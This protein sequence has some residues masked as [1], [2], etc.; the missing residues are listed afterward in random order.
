MDKRQIIVAL[1]W[2][3]LLFGGCG[4]QTPNST[5]RLIEGVPQKSH[6]VSPSAYEA[7]IQGQ[8]AL[9]KGDTPAALRFLNT[10]LM[11][12]SNSPY[13][14]T[15]VAEIYGSMKNS[16][17]AYEHLQQALKLQPDFPDALLL[18][19]RLYWQEKKLSASEKSF[20]RYIQQN[21]SSSAGYLLYAELLERTW[22]PQLARQ[23]LED[24]ARRVPDAAEAHY[25][26][27]V[28]CLRQVDYVCAQR[29]LQILLQNRSDPETL[30]HLAHV[31]RALG[32]LEEGIRLLREAFD[33]SDGDPAVASTLIEL[34]QQTDKI[35]AIDDLLE[36]FSNNI[37]DT[38]EQLAALAELCLEAR[39][40]DRALRL[41][42]NQLKLSDSAVW[43]LIQAEALTQLKKLPEAKDV[44]RALLDSPQGVSAT[45]RL[46]RL[47][48]KESQYEE[49]GK[50]LSH[51][52]QQYG[53]QDQLLITLSEV[54]FAQG[55]AEHSIQVIRQALRIYPNNRKLRFGLGAALERVG[56]WQE[57]IKEMSQILMQD[58]EDAMAHN[59]I[60]YT[61]V[62]HGVDLASAQ[63]SI[64]RALFLQ[65]GEGFVLDSLG[66]FYFRKGQTIEAQRLLLMASRLSPEDP[67]I[68]SHLAEVKA[69]LKDRFGALKLLK[70][71]LAN[72][73]DKK[74]TA[75]LKRRLKQL[76]SD[77]NVPQNR[78]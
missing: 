20:K 49:A 9:A 73:E 62:E 14:H 32:N 52:L 8:I 38:P 61:Q 77:I 75:N 23:L 1:I 71:A 19:G 41:A 69:T 28:L 15:V 59:F 60:G 46:A 66:W 3:A 33:R 35:Q 13:L 16:K 57:A 72:S 17:Q 27:S 34:L 50:L 65:P 45:L 43:F 22:R 48:Q 21:P 4:H 55:R 26:L 11:Y 37:E 12:D 29:E 53:H 67:E 44:L 36:I 63:H 74:L 68:L 6:Y 47:L 51:R 30:I 25:R 31:E 78:N 18:Q 40:P 5:V 39:R 7:Y 56:R 2:G 58:P 76:E 10:A 64:L 70:Q 54:L 24:M 42:E